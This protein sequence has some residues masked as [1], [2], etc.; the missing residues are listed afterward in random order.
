MAM[1]LRTAP[2]RQ[3]S[4]NPTTAPAMA[5][6]GELDDEETGTGGGLGNV[7]GRGGVGGGGRGGGCGG[8]GALVAAPL[9]RVTPVTPVKPDDCSSVT[10]TA[11]LVEPNVSSCTPT[12]VA[13]ATL[14]TSTTNLTSTPTTCV[15]RRRPVAYW[16]ITC[17]TRQAVGLSTRSLANAATKDARSTAAN[18][19]SV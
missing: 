12:E 18:V 9:I 6:I 1:M 10:S 5:A 11:L 8:G 15:R 17:V 4:T 3:T 14:R 16:L 13:T 2:G 7:G 19:A